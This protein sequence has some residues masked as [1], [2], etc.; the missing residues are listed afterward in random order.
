MAKTN[1]ESHIGIKLWL[2]EISSKV[3]EKGQKKKKNV[4]QDKLC[5]VAT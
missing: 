1:E 5:T 4:F 3:D 2:K